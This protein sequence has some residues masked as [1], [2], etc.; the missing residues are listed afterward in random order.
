MNSDSTIQLSLYQAI[1]IPANATNPSLPVYGQTPGISGAPNNF[2][3]ARTNIISAVLNGIH[4]LYANSPG[5][6]TK[7]TV[8]VNIFMATATAA[9][10]TAAPYVFN[11]NPTPSIQGW[12]GPPATPPAYDGKGGII[13][14]LTNNYSLVTP[15]GGAP[16]WTSSTIATYNG[17]GFTPNVKNA[18]WAYVIARDQAIAACMATAVL[19]TL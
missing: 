9:Y 1:A 7:G 2:Q 15:P 8:G 19:N 14:D 13:G 16:Q 11:A 17:I 4:Q 3:I 12:T 10:G 6:L 18:I 5:Q